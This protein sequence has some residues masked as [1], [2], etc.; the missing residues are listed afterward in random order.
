MYLFQEIEEATIRYTDSQQAI[1]DYVLV[2]RGDLE[3]HSM[4]EIAEATYTSKP[5]L[6]RFAQSFGFDGWHDFARSIVQEARYQE[7]HYCAVDP[8]IPF[9]EDDDLKDI[10]RKI[11]DLQR[12]SISDTA[13]Q[14]DPEYLEHAARMLV[15]ARRIAIFAMSPNSLVAALFKRKMESI[16]ILVNIAPVDEIGITA[17]ALDKRDCALVI[18]YSGNNP[19]REPM[20][21]IETLKKQEVPI[22]GITSGG[23]NLVRRTANVAF[24]ISSRE[25]LFSKISDYST[26]ISVVHILD[27][28]FSCCF[29]QSYQ[30]NLQHK[31]ESSRALEYRRSAS[32]PGMREDASR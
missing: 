26:E 22:I 8:N 32:L 12:E 15:G 27:V 13:A 14:L 3:N 17:R 4:R 30:R 6:T 18:S 11:A 2:T 5:T 19:R 31:L 20:S 24:T 21:V 10:A 23:D 28:L 7:E 29:A 9:T 1:A 25:R 16:G